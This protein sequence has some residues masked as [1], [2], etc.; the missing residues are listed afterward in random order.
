MYPCTCEPYLKQNT[1]TYT[2]MYLHVHS[3]TCD[4][5]LTR[6]RHDGEQAGADDEALTEVQNGQRVLYAKR[7]LLQTP[8]HCL[9]RL[10]LRHFV[11]KILQHVCINIKQYTRT[12][13]HSVAYVRSLRHLRVL[14]VAQRQRTYLA[15]FARGTWT[16]SGR[17]ES[18]SR[19]EALQHTH[20][21]HVTSRDTI[22]ALHSTRVINR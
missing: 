22:Q 20:T 5:V 8:Q 10:R 14:V 11:V 1:Y 12:R 21:T 17:G 7:S 18:L 6:Q 9:V 3:C 19:R 13:T 4:Y 16:A 2:Y 15:A